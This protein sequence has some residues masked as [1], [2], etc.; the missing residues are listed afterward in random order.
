MLLLDD[1]SKTLQTQLDAKDKELESL[2]NRV[3]DMEAQLKTSKVKE[4]AFL[5]L[6]RCQGIWTEL[7]LNAEDQA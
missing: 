4:E 5:L 2:R 6:D 7:G 3:I 1:K